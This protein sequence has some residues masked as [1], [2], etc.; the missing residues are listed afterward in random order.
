MQT[1]R[2]PSLEGL[3]RDVDTWLEEQIA[4]THV[5]DPRFRLW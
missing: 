4:R 5:L 3:L 2:L 1:R